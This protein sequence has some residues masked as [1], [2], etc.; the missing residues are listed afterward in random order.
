MKIAIAR[1]FDSYRNITQKNDF[2]GM[3]RYMKNMKVGGITQL[4]D[5]VA[6]WKSKKEVIESIIFFAIEDARIIGIV[7]GSLRQN[8]VFVDVIISKKKGTGRALMEAVVE[9]GAAHGKHGVELTSTPEAHGFYKRI[10]FRR[11]PLGIESKNIKRAKSLYSR[12]EHD[13]RDLPRSTPQKVIDRLES[14]R[15]S[16]MKDLVKSIPNRDKAIWYA[17]SALGHKKAFGSKMFINKNEQRYS[18]PKYSLAVDNYRRRKI[19]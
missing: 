11:G 14:S 13:V 4:N 8:S 3:L 1:D 18:L 15:S 19:K 10:G 2:V 16:A 9:Y 6:T 5:I 7:I 12:V 17:Y